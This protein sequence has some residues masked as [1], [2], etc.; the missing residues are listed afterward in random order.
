MKKK[1]V[2]DTGENWNKRYQEIVQL[3]EGSRSERSAK[4]SALVTL[5]KDCE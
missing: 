1:T 3:P 2:Y 5:N 4:L